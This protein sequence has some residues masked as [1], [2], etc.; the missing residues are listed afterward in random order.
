MQPG[1]EPSPL[2]SSGTMH[3]TDSPHAER[4]RHP[5]RRRDFGQQKQTPAQPYKTGKDRQA[6]DADNSEEIGRAEAANGAEESNGTEDPEAVALYDCSI[7]TGEFLMKDG[8]VSCAEHFICNDC[9]VQTFTLAAENPVSGIFPVKC[10]MKASGSRRGPIILR[11]R[12]VQQL[13]PHEVNETYGRKEQEYYT[14]PAL[15][16]YCVDYRAWLPPKT[17]QDKGQYSLATCACGTTMCVGCKGAWQEHH[18]CTDPND[19]D[20]KPDWLP[21]YSDDCRIKKCPGCRMYI[22][23]E[24]ACNH[25]TCQFCRYEWCFICLLPWEDF[26]AADGC[27]VYRDPEDG[28]D[29]EGYENTERGL[30]RDTG[31]NREGLN[32]KG[33]EPLAAQDSNIGPNHWDYDSDRDSND[34]DDYADHHEHQGELYGWGEHQGELYGWGTIYQPEPI[35]HIDPEEEAERE[36]RDQLDTTFPLA[37]HSFDSLTTARIDCGHTWSYRNTGDS[38]SV[39]DYTMPYFHFRCS[40]CGVIACDFCRSDWTRRLEFHVPHASNMVAVLEWAEKGEVPFKTHKKA[41][42]RAM[43]EADAVPVWSISLMFQQYEKSLF[44]L[45]PFL[46]FDFGIKEMIDALEQEMERDELYIAEEDVG[47]AGNAMTFRL[48]T[49][50]FAPLLW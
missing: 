44:E 50:P 42:W 9:V 39:C 15:K 45:Q 41:F 6:Q 46:Y 28:Y 34:G 38:C 1:T 49:N 18:R 2:P 25:M 37:E 40:T 7:C 16:L 29:D 47:F 20:A 24:S 8:I 32:R 43:H 36:Y 26:H 17:F 14:P 10:C 3:G 4:R 35:V 31:L 13:L 30:H 48:D 22:E 23:H 33:E 19:P 11:R 12:L 21:P 5:R 27:P